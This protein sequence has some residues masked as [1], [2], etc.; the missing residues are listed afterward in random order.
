[1]GVSFSAYKTSY[2]R[3][4]N[5]CS[6]REFVH[7]VWDA[8]V[9]ANKSV[10]G[11]RAVDRS[12]SE[13]WKY[14]YTAFTAESWWES[15]GKPYYKLW[16][17]MCQQLES[18]RLNFNCQYLHAPYQVFNLM[19][20]SSFA[21]TTLLAVI[22]RADESEAL[23]NMLESC[24]DDASDVQRQILSHLKDESQEVASRKG[25]L[26]NRLSCVWIDSDNMHYTVDCPMYENEIV[27]ESIDNALR[28]DSGCHILHITKEQARQCCR[29]AVAAAM[30]AINRH[31]LVAP[32]IDQEVLLQKF[33]G[34]RSKAS[35]KIAEEKRN[36]EIAKCKGWKVGSEIDLPRPHV[37][38]SG[39][40]EERGGELTYGHIRS[41]HMKMQPCGPN[42][43][44]RKLIFVEPTVVRP[45][46]P[47][48][49]MHGYRIRTK[50]ERKARA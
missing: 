33:P 31:K 30:F 32:D 40:P 44:D 8:L 22:V 14:S 49:Q 19:P 34:G 1:M 28:D 16:P 35:Q 11:Q 36:R 23:T 9:E 15:S 39:Q 25:R 18:T 4:G 13:M 10:C 41:G 3:Y 20:A 24:S 48:R 6:R 37:I 50:E 45:D 29:L 2:E 12:V 5:G 43:Q 38:R 27:D 21:D 46:L 17:A 42:N 47:I 7:G 26:I